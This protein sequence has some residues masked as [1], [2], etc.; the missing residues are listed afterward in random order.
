MNFTFTKVQLKIYLHFYSRMT[1]GNNFFL[2]MM[3]MHNPMSDF[4]DQSEVKSMP[5]H[6][7][8]HIRIS[9]QFDQL[10]WFLKGLTVCC[11]SHCITRFDEL[12]WKKYFI[13]RKRSVSVPKLMQNMAEVPATQPQSFIQPHQRRE[14]EDQAAIYHALV[15]CWPP[16]H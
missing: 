10:A 9:M 5:G 1:F 15:R 13:G 11:T 16:Y 2:I 8:S 12:A 6:M 14:T 7:H 3:C 4:W